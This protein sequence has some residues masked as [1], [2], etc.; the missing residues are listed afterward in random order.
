[1]ILEFRKS[2]IKHKKYRAI[3]TK[4]GK[5]KTADFGHIDYEHYQDQTVDFPGGGVYTHLNH[6]DK[7]RQKRYWKR[8]SKIKNA[9]GEYTIR[10]KYSPG[11]FSLNFL[12]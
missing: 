4:N 10:K 8:H 2:P 12:W 6:N 5:I 1:M 9:D 3:F 7:K 11:W